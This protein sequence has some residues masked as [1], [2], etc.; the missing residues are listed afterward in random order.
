MLR[1]VRRIVPMNDETGKSGVM[2]EGIASKTIA[3]LTELWITRS[4]RVDHRDGIDHA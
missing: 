3:V 4:N 2:I 1:P